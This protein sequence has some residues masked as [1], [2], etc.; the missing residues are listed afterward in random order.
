MVYS[1]Y[2]GSSYT[3]LCSSTYFYKDTPFR[4]TLYPFDLI[5]AKAVS[6]AEERVPFV[7]KM[8]I[9]LSCPLSK[10]QLAALMR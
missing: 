4:E 5:V 6:D 10:L 8:I 3:K 9:F 2:F 1:T 7:Q